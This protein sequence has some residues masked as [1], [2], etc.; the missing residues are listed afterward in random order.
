MSRF[1]PCPR[2]GG[3]DWY[4]TESRRTKRGIRRRRRC[5]ECDHGLT[6]LE[7]PA[8]ELEALKSKSEKLTQ[9]RSHAQTALQILDELEEQNA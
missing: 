7:V 2:C 4:I 5:C 1:F 9:A 3:D 8:T 6:T